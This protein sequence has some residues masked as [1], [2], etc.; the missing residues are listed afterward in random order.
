MGYSQEL[1]NS[2]D[3]KNER[4]NISKRQNAYCSTEKGWFGSDFLIFKAYILSSA[5]PT[6]HLYHIHLLTHYSNTELIVWSVNVISS[7]ELLIFSLFS[8]NFQGLLAGQEISDFRVI[9]AG[10]FLLRLRT[11]WV[12]DD[13]LTELISEWVY[14]RILSLIW[15]ARL[16]DLFF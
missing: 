10:N 9:R 16:C 15:P 3:G 6:Y 4:N 13:N 14:S 1:G 8:P 7:L 5:N 11:P 12:G 2:S